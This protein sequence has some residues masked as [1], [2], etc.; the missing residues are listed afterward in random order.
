MVGV[1]LHIAVRNPGEALLFFHCKVILSP[2]DSVRE[3][4]EKYIPIKPV[5]Y[6]FRIKIFRPL[7]ITSFPIFV[8]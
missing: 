6:C 1:V 4:D 7:V 3:R 8:R 5:S 2:R